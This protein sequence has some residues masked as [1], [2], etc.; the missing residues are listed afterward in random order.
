MLY[1]SFLISLEWSD[2]D[3]YPYIEYIPMFEARRVYFSGKSS[4]IITLP[5]N[6]VK[7]NGIKAGD[8]VLMKIGKDFITIYPKIVKSGKIAFIDAKDLRM[9][10]LL[11]RII[12]YYL[13]GFDTI[14]IKI[15]N[16]EH[17][18][19]VVKSS[20]ILMGAEVVEDLGK[21]IV[22]EI[23]LDNTRLKTRVILERM[24]NTCVGMV[25]DF[26]NAL[27]RFDKFVCTSIMARE[28]EVD[29]M[30]FLLLRQLKLASMHA[31][32]AATLEIPIESVHEYRTVVRSLERIADHAYKMAENL[33]KLEKSADELCD[34]VNL[35]IDMLSTAVIAFLNNE[36][37][38]AEEVLEDFDRVAEIENRMY[39]IVLTREIE[40]ALLL[41][42]IL[43][44]LSRIASYSADIAEV[45]INLAVQ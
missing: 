24:A 41:K 18:R 14:R 26:C 28:N 44:S 23:F 20:E 21:E 3:I 39:E 29:R 27:R 40:E 36:T 1:I 25:S 10:S 34:F 31:D 13:A 4:Y 22:M 9:E 2:R 17:R 35:D 33:L 37:D 15:Y 43:D 8:E 11:R 5:K 30:H 38:L 12:S 19:A 32:I 42:S 16:E 7:G 45:V 6:W